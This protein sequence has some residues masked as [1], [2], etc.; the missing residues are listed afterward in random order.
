MDRATIGRA[1]EPFFTTKGVGEGTGLG[2]STVYGIVK[3]S[4]GFVWVYSEPG[5]GSSFKLYFPVVTT[6][7]GLVDQRG[8]APTARENET[9]L[10][11]E[12]EAMVRSIMAR[13]LRDC[14]YRV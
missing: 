4:G 1:F 2:L 13:T 7:P 5:H 9:V 6:S 8:T 12:D 11:A 10:V 3:Q 14:G